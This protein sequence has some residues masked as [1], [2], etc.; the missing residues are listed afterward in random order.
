MPNQPLAPVDKAQ[1]AIDVIAYFPVAREADGTV[2]P[3]LTNA[4]LNA[5]L[6]E[7]DLEQCRRLRNQHGAL[8]Q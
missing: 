1:A 4:Q 8:S 2:T 7:E 6:E 5:I 3:Y